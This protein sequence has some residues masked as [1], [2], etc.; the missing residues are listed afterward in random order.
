GGLSDM[1]INRFFVILG[2]TVALLLSV[3]SAFADEETATDEQEQSVFLI[4]GTIERPPFATKGANGEWSGYSI[5]LF[6]EVA[7][8]TDIE[9]EFQELDLFTEMID[10]VVMGDLDMAV[11][12]ISI[13]PEREELLDFS[14]PIYDSGFQIVVSSATA[15]PSVWSIILESGI[16]W[17]VGIAF[18]ILL[19]VAHLMWFF[20]R[21]MP[22]EK[23]DYFRDDYFG[24]IF[25]AF[26]WAFIIVTIGGFENERPE[27]FMGRVL[28]IF[29]IIASLFFVSTFTAQI[30]TA[31]TISQLESTIETVDDLRGKR[32]GSV[33]GTAFADYLDNEG[34][35]YAT[36]PDFSDVLTDLQR[37]NLDAAIGDAPVVQ[38]FVANEG[39]DQVLLAGDVF[40]PDKFAFAVEDNHPQYE[41]I[42]R[43]L[44]EI[45]KDGTMTEIRSRYFGQ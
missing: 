4:V 1:N 15:A 34:I 26:W 39:E 27:N 3:S 40:E 35:A 14:Q 41:E 23:H 37:G 24:G 33:P 19:M 18:M 13:T 42:N 12:N 17:F 20:E 6:R 7:D 28:A 29:W 22:K 30:T 8:R 9:Y 44:I 5:E 16:L 11:A 38:F 36:Y 31:L 43:A 32:V 21:G 2:L 45:Q 10:G 25:D